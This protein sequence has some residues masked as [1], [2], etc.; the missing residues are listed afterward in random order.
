LGGVGRHDV[1]EGLGLGLGGG[2]LGG[3]L[4]ELRL[5]GLL[6]ELRLSWLL[7]GL[8]NLSSLSRLDLRLLDSLGSLWNLGSLSIMNLR[9]LCKL[10]LGSWLLESLSKLG[11]LSLGLLRSRRC[12]LNNLRFLG[13]SCYL[14]NLRLLCHL[15][16]LPHNLRSIPQRLL[17][18]LLHRILYQRPHNF[19]SILHHHPI[20]PILL[21]RPALPLT[22]L[23]LYLWHIQ[24]IIP[25][26]RI[27]QRPPNSILLGLRRHALAEVGERCLNSRVVCLEG[28]FYVGDVDV[29]EVL[30]VDDGVADGAVAAGAEA[31]GEQ[32]GAE[33]QA[34]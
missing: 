30:E 17:I 26:N 10:L 21:L 28:L 6:G 24:R 7:D 27:R 34:E 12:D 4:G 3:L 25:T 22:P 13:R 29:F 18:C 14:Y 5:G 11:N 16:R 1:L 20:L 19:L 33:H 23:L 9:L 2:E 15:R 32:K 31:G 8:R